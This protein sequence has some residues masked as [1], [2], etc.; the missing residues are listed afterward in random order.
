MGN[1]NSDSITDAVNGLKDNKSD[2]KVGRARNSVLGHVTVWTHNKTDQ[3]SL[4]RGKMMDEELGAS[5]ARLKFLV[6]GKRNCIPLLG[7]S[8]V[9]SSQGWCAAVIYELR[10]PAF[11]VSLY[12]LLAQGHMPSEGDLWSIIICI[13]RVRLSNQA[14]SEY[15]AAKIEHGYV[16]NKSIIFLEGSYHLMDSLFYDMNHFQMAKLFQKD[17]LCSPEVFNQI[18]T[19]FRSPVLQWASRSDLFSLGLTVLEIMLTDRRHDFTQSMSLR[20]TIRMNYRLSNL[21]SMK[22][23]SL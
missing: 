10:I 16:C 12:D 6:K 17:H 18:T 5:Q 11:E 1:S 19:R 22:L 23:S 13:T 3:V 8:K 21:C 20:C 2:Y 9:E 4:V 14:L 7:I 15:E